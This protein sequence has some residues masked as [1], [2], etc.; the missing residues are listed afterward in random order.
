MGLNKLYT[1]IRG[2]I[3]MMNPLPSL[4]QAFSMLIQD[5]KQWE[6]KINSQL[7]TEYISFN[8]STSRQKIFRTKY[9]AGTS[10]GKNQNYRSHVICEN[11]KWPGHTKEKC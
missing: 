1:V 4:A 2:N 8:A 10:S 6:I 5:E 9:S 7:F 3:L 11:S